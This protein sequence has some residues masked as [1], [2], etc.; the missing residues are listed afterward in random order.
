M[1]VRHGFL[2]NP[3]EATPVITCP[4]A[5]DTPSA[6]GKNVFV[7]YGRADALDS[8]RRLTDALR[9]HGHLVWMDLDNIDK[10]GLFDVRIEQGIRSASVLLGVM[11][12]AAVR[13]ESVCRDEVVFALN[14][15]KPVVPL[16]AHRDVRAPLLLARRIP[17]TLT[18]QT[19]G[20]ILANRA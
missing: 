8:C 13:G 17:P 4:P 9:Q 18:T 5:T 3:A 1:Q 7:S 10:G 14:E 6:A 15:G 11:T 19:N 12:P 16:R 20:N 2:S